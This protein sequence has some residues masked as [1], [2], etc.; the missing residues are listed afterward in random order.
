MTANE[1]TIS[2]MQLLTS[3]ELAKIL[4][5]T[6]KTLERWRGTGEGPRFVRISA[7]N[8]RYRAQDLE[9]FIKMRVCISTASVPMDR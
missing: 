7:S 1:S 8:V 5:V 6:T 9:D 3:K 4:N 2:A